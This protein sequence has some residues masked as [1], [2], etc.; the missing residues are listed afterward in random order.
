M[1]KYSINDLFDLY[2]ASIYNLSL[3]NY[4]VY[5]CNICGKYFISKKMRKTCSRACENKAIELGNKKIKVVKQILRKLI[6]FIKKSRI[7]ITE[8]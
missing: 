3:T 7:F 8:T 1:Y 5:N 4:K 2:Y 6:F